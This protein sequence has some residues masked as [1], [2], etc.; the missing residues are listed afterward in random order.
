MPV[1]K[2]EETEATD[3]WAILPEDTI[4]EVEVEDITEREVPGKDGREGWTK[5]E[6]RFRINAI[7][8]DLEADYGSLVG[9]K[10]W[11]SVGARFTEHPD[12]KLRP[13]AQALLNMGELTVGFELDT[14][15]LIG[16]KARGITSQYKK[17]DGSFNHQIGGL[18]PLTSNIVE[19]PFASNQ[20]AAATTSSSRFGYSEEPP[21]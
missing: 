7:P 1:Y 14:D 3:D 10:I 4:V 6:F 13:W 20:F 9:S 12:N 18:L 21:F 2:L 5:L 16:R 17:R 15:M 8:T 19:D 11:G